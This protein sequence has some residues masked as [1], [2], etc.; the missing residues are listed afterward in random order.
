MKKD[1][2]HYS[3]SRKDI[4]DFINIYQL[5][6][7]YEDLSKVELHKVLYEHFGTISIDGDL[8]EL[9]EYLKMSIPTKMNLNV[10]K[11]DNIYEIIKRL[12]F[13]CRNNFRIKKTDYSSMTDILFD[14]NFI[15][16]CGDLPSV[17]YV[18]NKLNT[19]N[20]VKMKLIPKLS[21][22][23]RTNVIVSNGILKTNKGH[24]LVK[25]E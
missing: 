23:P 22:K 7:D 4:I 18:I 2:V 21:R 20:K 13:Y 3:H 10:E 12:L 19:D 24:F 15:C 9:K 6:L 8:N 11:K 25:F 17:R 1:C 16:E 14:A 5:N